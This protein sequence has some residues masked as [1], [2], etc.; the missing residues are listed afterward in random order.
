[1]NKVNA[2]IIDGQ[3]GQV[4]NKSQNQFHIRCSTF[5]RRPLCGNIFYHFYHFYNITLIVGSLER[6]LTGQYQ[7]IA[8]CG[9]ATSLAVV[10][11]QS[12][13]SLFFFLIEMQLIH[14]VVLISFVQQ[15]DSVTH[16]HTFFFVSFSITAY[17]SI[18]NIV[19]CANTIQ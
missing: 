4:L 7:F 15:S 19:P 5:K 12:V 9:I 2:I 11:Q 16:I 14:N 8:A 6:N 3:L 17:H 13:M 1:M 10:D 18:L